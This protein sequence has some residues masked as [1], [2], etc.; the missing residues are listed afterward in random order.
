MLILTKRHT[1]HKIGRK[2]IRVIGDFHVPNHY[3]RA[4]VVNIPEYGPNYGLGISNGVSGIGFLFRGCRGLIRHFHL[5]QSKCSVM[6]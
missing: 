2:W 3:R 5:R 6:V 4:R 1:N